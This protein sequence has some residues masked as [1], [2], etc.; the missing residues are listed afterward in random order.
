[1]AGCCSPLRGYVRRLRV[2]FKDVYNAGGGRNRISLRPIDPYAQHVARSFTL[3]FLVLL[4]LGVWGMTGEQRDAFLTS[5]V[6]LALVRVWWMTGGGWRQFLSTRN[7]SVGIVF[8]GVIVAM[9]PE[10][11]ALL[12][13]VLITL[14]FLHMVYSAFIYY[15]SR[16]RRT[17]LKHWLYKPVVTVTHSD[18]ND[19]RRHSETS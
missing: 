15:C 8:V 3:G 14:V 7:M 5:I 11:A 4:I 18:D 12:F 16:H 17:V 13:R 6:V 1:M 9:L 2:Y 19:G 10:Y